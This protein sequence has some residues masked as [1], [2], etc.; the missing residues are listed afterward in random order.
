MIQ[1]LRMVGM[2]ADHALFYPRC[3]PP[4]QQQ[5][6]GA[7]A[8]ADPQPKIAVRMGRSPPWTSRCAPRSS[9]PAAGDAGDHGGW[10]YVLVAN[11]LGIVSH[12]SD[13]VLGDAREPGGG[14][15]Q[16]P[17]VFADPQRK[18][19]DPAP[20]PELQQRVPPLIPRRSQRRQ[21][22]RLAG[23]VLRSKSDCVA[24]SR[25]RAMVG[26]PVTSTT[27]RSDRQSAMEPGIASPANGS[28]RLQSGQN[29]RLAR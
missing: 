22:T 23:R 18:K 3:S 11:D 1:T 17:Q 24:R 4:G 14:A 12:I 25:N 28:A 6:V 21:K 13:E 20:H 19:F 29:R 10:S 27:V 2:L 7:G 8:G 15:Q 9:N 5:R 16:D 26:I